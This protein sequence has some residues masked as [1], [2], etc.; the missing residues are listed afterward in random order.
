VKFPEKSAET[1]RSSNL[2]YSI[3]CLIDIPE[4]APLRRWFDAT[5]KL[6]VCR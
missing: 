4:E 5:K 2:G 1:N 3:L 6:E